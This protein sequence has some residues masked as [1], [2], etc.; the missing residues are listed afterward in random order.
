MGGFFATRRR[1]WLLVIVG[2]AALL[3]ASFAGPTLYWRVVGW[4]RA[5][6]LYLGRPASY[7]RERLGDWE[8]VWYRLPQRVLGDPPR[9]TL[10]SWRQRPA[11]WRPA[12]DAVNR[13]VPIARVFDPG[14]AGRAGLPPLGN[15][16]PAAFPVIVHLLEDPSPTV[17]R[18]AVYGLA[19]Q[20]ARPSEEVVGLLERYLDDRDDD[21]RDVAR[22]VIGWVPRP[23]TRGGATSGSE[24]RPG[25]FR[26]GPF[27]RFP[28][29]R[30]P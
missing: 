27:P 19:A 12:F 16:D 18:G 9:R 25:G 24:T 1:R 7:W 20:R 28:S 5:E 21:V 3:L 17:R 14:G 13:Y 8:A 10:M 22:S 2:T 29:D 6:P 26:L 4:W 30:G 23:P 15:G 11:A